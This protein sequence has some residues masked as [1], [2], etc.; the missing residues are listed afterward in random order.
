MAFNFKIDDFNS[1]IEKRGGLQPLNRY[2]MY[3]TPVKGIASSIY[4]DIPL[5]C[6][7]VSLPG[8]SIATADYKT[9]GPVIKIGRESIYAD[10]NATFILTEDMELK[11]YFDSWMNKVQNDESYDPGYYRDYVSDIYVSALSGKKV[12]AV[13]TS[14]DQTNYTARIE[15]AFPTSMA[16]VALSHTANNTYAKLQVTFTYR[17][18]IHHT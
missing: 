5:L 8:R 14:P 6:E 17:R 4:N 1:L 13:G 3:I 16:D 12:A 2:A 11:K 9:Y 10:L 7:E 18:C 15:D